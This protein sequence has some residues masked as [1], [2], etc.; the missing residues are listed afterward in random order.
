MLIDVRLKPPFID[1]FFQE[2]INF[3]GIS[4][5]YLSITHINRRIT[6]PIWLLWMVAKSPVGRWFIHVYPV[7]TPFFISFCVF[8]SY[9]YQ[10]VQDFAR[11]LLPAGRHNPKRPAR[12]VRG[13]L[14]LDVP[15]EPWRNA[16]RQCGYEWDVNGTFVC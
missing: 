6:I 16:G 10:L 5:W 3:D 9:L 12:H 14:R 2:R 15:F 8:H 13:K 11:G 7:I 1:V 4:H